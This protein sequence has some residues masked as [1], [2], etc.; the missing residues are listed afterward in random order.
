MSTGG[1]RAG[2][3]FIELFVK[4][5]LDK[6]LRSARAKLTSFASS[7]NGMGRN[8]FSFAAV[9][10][11]PLALA[12]GTFSDFADKMSAVRAVSGATEAQF[13]QLEKTARA[14]GGST[15]F[16]ASQVA[17]G[18]KY[19][20]QAG[21]STEQII[22]GIPAVLNLARA[23]A[24][25]L[26]VASDIA[27]DVGS[28]FGMTADEL[29]RVADVIAATASS[30][31][32]SVGM[33]GETFKYAAPLA[34][35]AGQSIEDTAT[36]IGWMGN[37]GIKA[38]MA[39]TDLALI[40]KNLG[41]DAREGLAAVGVETVDAEGNIRSVIDVMKEVGEATKDMTQAD[42]L[43]FFSANFD[44]AA[45]SAIIMAD[46]GD[47]IDVLREKIENSEGAAAKMAEMMDDNLGGSF[48]KFLSAIE[49]VQIS[50]GKSVE[51][52]LR[53]FIDGAAEAASIVAKFIE[54]NGY[55]VQVFGAI[56]VALAAAAAGF[57]GLALV[58]NIVAGAVTALI[59]LW[60][61]LTAVITFLASPIGLVVAALGLGVAAF[62]YF[63]GAGSAAARAVGGAFQSLK[64]TVGPVLS[65]L[66]DALNAGEWELAAQLLWSSIKTVFFES[67]AAILKE[68]QDWVGQISHTMG[69]IA[70]GWGLEM[71]R[72]G[73]FAKQEM[74]KNLVQVEKVRKEAAIDAMLADLPTVTAY[75]LDDLKTETDPL[76]DLAG[77]KAYGLDDL[78]D[79]GNQ[80]AKTWDMAVGTTNSFAAGRIGQQ[81]RPME[82]VENEL[83]SVNDK[84]AKLIDQGE[85]QLEFGS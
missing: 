33:M 82:K 85:D 18:M 67:M 68:L 23:G 80:V 10:A 71:Q 22:S 49:A 70:R 48:R 40:L 24:I 19:L 83:Q 57:L 69:E 64:E 51:G 60:G 72:Q 46:A 6:G 37:S 13:A 75:G 53:S 3:A 34:K 12:I 44:R 65:A 74:Q 78:G 39:G 31:N 63:S 41:G 26:G 42:R 21:Y 29:G 5:G 8:L 62:L 36:A 84:L 20:G 54:E 55:I 59:G 17:E 38:S 32:T 66:R 47:S 61:V 2:G 11:A 56:V 43:A 79:V 35:A 50:I 52:P 15:S 25:D 9:G 77:A 81:A 16:S 58:I 28:A 45:K 7:M 1:V 14:L 73:L 30:A 76:G 27:S 4:D